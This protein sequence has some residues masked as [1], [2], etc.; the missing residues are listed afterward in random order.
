MN[1]DVHTY[2]LPRSM[3]VAERVGT[4]WFGAQPVPPVNSDDPAGS[5]S[6][7][8]WLHLRNRVC[9]SPMWTALF[10]DNAQTLFA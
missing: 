3:V 5:D 10:S 8:R 4:P 2:L 9:V 1:N 6:E 7:P